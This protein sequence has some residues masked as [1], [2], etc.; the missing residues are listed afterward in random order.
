VKNVSWTVVQ[1]R[2]Y[3]DFKYGSFDIYV[4]KKEFVVRGLLKRGGQSSLYLKGVK[5]G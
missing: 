5:N 2:N 3:N 4:T 1:Y